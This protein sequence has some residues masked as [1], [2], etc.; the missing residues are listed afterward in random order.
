MRARTLVALAGGGLLFAAIGITLV[1]AS[2]HEDNK[3][4]FLSLALTVGLSFLVSGVVALWRRPDNRTGL[5]LVLVAYL[6][7]LG[8][9]TESNN[10]WVYTIGGLFSSLALGAF[11]HL[12]LAFPTGTLQGRRDVLLVAG[13]YGLVFLGSA[14]RLLFDEHPDASC[15]DCTSTIA[16]TD[17]GT[18]ASAVNLLLAVLGLALVGAVL[19]T[20]VARYVRSSGALRRALGPVLGTGVIVMLVLLLELAVGAI[21]ED[22]S[23]PL[24]FVFLAAFAMVP[25]AF[26]A[27]I[28]RSRLARSS[29]GDLLLALS[30]GTPIREALRQVLKDP[31]LEVAY[32]LPDSGRYVTS[33]GRPL[34]DEGPSA[35]RHVSLVEYAGR[36][37]AALLHD[38]SLAEEPELVEA[39][40]AGAGLWLENDRLQAQLRAQVEFL[41]TTVNTS[42]SLLCTL[43]REGRI[44]NLNDAAVRASGYDDQEEV[45]WQPFWDVY[46]APDEQDHGRHLFNAA[47]P[48]HEATTFEHT[49]V[50]RRGEERTI[51]WSTAPLFDEQG[52]VRNVIYGGLD[53][54][55][56]RRQLVA[57]QASEE[58]L[59]AVIK[60]SPIAIVEYALDGTI[61]R[62]NPAAEQIFGWTADEVV[63][64][65]PLHRPPDRRDIA[66]AAGRVLEGEIYTSVETQRR[67]K[68]GTLVD[69]EA[70]AAPVFDASGEVAGYI[71]LY[72][73]I[74][75]RKQ[76]EEEVRK[77]RARIVQAADDARRVL[78]RNLHD[79]AQQRLVAL[80]LS[81]RLAQARLETEPDEANRLL[82]AAREELS[83]AIEDLRELARGIHPAILTD[84][85]LDAALV[86]LSLRSPI[87]VSVDVP[88]E[89]LPGPVEA[90]AYYVIAESLTNVAKYAQASAAT[91]RVTCENGHAVVEVRDDGIGGAD[92]ATGT[93]LRGL[94]DRVEALAGSLDVDSPVGGGTLVRADIPLQ[95]G[96]QG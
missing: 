39:V 10:D 65:P 13:T 52:N 81:L 71:A 49:F 1:V 41:E 40:T 67:R 55:E 38:A 75:A 70:S 46:V 51:A 60:A 8:A 76:Q 69:L 6:W 59:A 14:A 42:P 50:D 15:P 45:R 68:D 64:G 77:S 7:F 61:A 48:F 63:G 58:R 24:Y 73:D 78:E 87:P 30:H 84:R 27:G 62:W 53:V 35:T 37:T 22:A 92:A 96:A 18:A 72:A 74:T 90:A 31:T 12:L 20:V 21:S 66:E 3:A 17:S 43:D 56:R 32:W 91:V 47:G 86:A 11:V 83:R 4:A 29:V 23:R 26:L 28:L 85:G 34:R 89:R 95:S 94:A 25:I 57:I 88:E 44:V 2:N 79:G 19:Y 9:L 36:P 5:L 82:D 93:G 80:S 16:V 54:T 33:D